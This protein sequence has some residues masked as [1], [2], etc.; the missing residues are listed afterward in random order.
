MREMRKLLG[1]L[2]L[3]VVATAAAYADPVPVSV[4]PLTLPYGT[5]GPYYGDVTDPTGTSFQPLICFS[6]LNGLGAPW[7]GGLKYSINT[8]E[9]GTFGTWGLTTFQFNVLGYLADQLFAAP[10]TANLQHAIWYYAGFVPAGFF[11][12]L[13]PAEQVE[14]TALIAAAEAAVKAG[15]VTGDYFLFAP[16]SS[17]GTG[18]QP[19]IERAPEPG[20]LLLLGSGIF[21]IAGAIR[22]KMAR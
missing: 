2:L 11:A 19:L 12:S 21:G 8:V 6:E 9:A 4:G 15:F 10:G 17:P 1:I 13:P 16:N 7:T 5:I 22:R 18:A 3:L 14:V 20:S